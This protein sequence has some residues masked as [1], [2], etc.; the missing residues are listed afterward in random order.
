MASGIV[1]PRQC[2]NM[3]S[4]A[5][6]RDTMM[7]ALNVPVLVTVGKRTGLCCPPTRTCCLVFH[8]LMRLSM[9]VWPQ[10]SRRGPFTF[11][12]GIGSLCAATL[13]MRP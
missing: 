6:D 10:L 1:M 13:G 3:V 5:I 2:G 4:R 7:Q 9:Q 11:Q 12:S 8:M